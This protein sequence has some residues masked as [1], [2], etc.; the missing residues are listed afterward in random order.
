MA[1][2]K[3]PDPVGKCIHNVELLSPEFSKTYGLSPI[4]TRVE[5]WKR[6]TP[7]NET[8]TFQLVD[9]F[10]SAQRKERQ[11]CFIRVLWLKDD[12]PFR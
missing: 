4:P 11:N 8:P 3:Y 6:A 10:I 12:P 7:G 1:E 5:K 2:N 9:V